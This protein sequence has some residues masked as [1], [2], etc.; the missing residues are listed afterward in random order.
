MS[1]GSSACTPAFFQNG[2]DFY[3]KLSYSWDQNGNTS[4]RQLKPWLDPLNTGA[5]SLNAKLCGTSLV[6]NFEASHTHVQTGYSTQFSYTGL[7][8]PETYEWVF[9][10]I[11]VSPANSTDPQPIVTY[12][13]SGQYT[14]R[15][16][17]T[18]GEYSSSEI[19]S[20]YILVDENGSSID[21][22]ENEFQFNIFPNP[23]SSKIYISQNYLK[24]AS[25]EIK[26]TL[27]QTLL[28]E[29]MSNETKLID[30]SS[31]NDG[32]Y[33]ISIF[34]DNHSTTKRLILNK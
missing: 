4:N 23:S 32:I 18:E 28:T 24:Y 11:N 25:I 29:S 10:G 27:G 16:D 22:K 7:G 19:K 3:G 21:I 5:T 9:Y 6:A 2:Y 14:V 31:F 20:T 26:N 13:N 33:F 12:S 1:T 34:N 30:L 17:V 15:L 8:N